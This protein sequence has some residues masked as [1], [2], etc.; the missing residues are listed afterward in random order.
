MALRNLNLNLKQNQSAETPTRLH[1]SDVR[2]SCDGTRVA[3]VSLDRRSVVVRTY[4]ELQ[5]L[6]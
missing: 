5:F 1:E 2:V 4:P 3:G 6:R